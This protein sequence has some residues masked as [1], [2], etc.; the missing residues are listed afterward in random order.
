MESAEMRSLDSLLFRAQMLNP[1]LYRKH[2]KQM[3]TQYIVRE[4]NRGARVQ[5]EK[6][7]PGL[8]SYAIE[9]YLQSGGPGMRAWV[10]Y[11]EGDFPAALKL[12]AA[13]L[14]G[15]RD[16]SAIHAQR[17][18]VF[19]LMGSYDSAQ[20]AFEQALT[21][22]RKEDDKRL[23]RLYEPKALLEHSIGMVREEKGDIP[24]AREAYGRA[25]QEDLAFY[26]AHQRLA[27]LALAVGDT[28]TALNEM[29][30]AVH[31]KGDDPN[32]RITYGYML[33]SAKQFDKATEHLRKAIE[34][35]PLYAT[36]YAVLAT[37]A[38]VQGRPGEALSHY[39]VFME[40]ASRHDP[41]LGQAQRRM[42]ALR[43]QTAQQVQVP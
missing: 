38:E 15:S 4:S 33:A 10:A 30:L 14:K 6:V 20:S 12:Y 18:R 32:L 25:L 41:N 43:A 24:G 35:E 40:H 27:T 28:V 39:R 9:S 19:F 11:S 37:V 34:L 21:H 22:W 2:D 36:A 3:F 42:A 5:S 7:D 8:L 31:V 16:K 23:V 1:F 17:G 13:A 29:E 26:P